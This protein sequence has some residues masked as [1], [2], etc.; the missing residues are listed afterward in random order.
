[1]RKA[2]DS[3]D[4]FL[5]IE[6]PEAVDVYLRPAPVFV[7]A[8]AYGVDFVIRMAWLWLSMWALFALVLPGSVWARE[9]TYSVLVG[10]LLLDLFFVFWLYYSVFE[11][12]WGGGN[13]WQAGFWL[14]GG[15]H[16]WYA[17]ILVK[18]AVA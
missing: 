15:E 8:A 6:T 10:L 18:L 3:L 2:A 7:R 17:N 9:N 14:E 13:A 4:T 5:R 16:S 1:M 12:W 11:M